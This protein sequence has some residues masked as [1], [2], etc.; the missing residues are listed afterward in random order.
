MSNASLNFDLCI[1]WVEI[2][3][4]WALNSR[5]ILGN[6]YRTAVRRQIARHYGNENKTTRQLKFDVWWGT[7]SCF[8]GLTRVKP[9]EKIVARQCISQEIRISSFEA[10][11]FACQ[12]VSNL[13][14]GLAGGELILNS[15]TNAYGRRPVTTWRAAWL[16][17]FCLA[18][19]ENRHKVPDSASSLGGKESEKWWR[20]VKIH[21]YCVQSAFT[22]LPMTHHAFCHCCHSLNI[23]FDHGILPAKS[24]IRQAEHNITCWQAAA[25]DC[26]LA[27]QAAPA[28]YGLLGYQSSDTAI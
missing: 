24:V 8:P 28:T 4:N 14:L 27:P 15:G 11:S 2:A 23:R 13:C 22:W 19:Y 5:I 6:D 21:H 7:K 16:E 9:C 20:L 3:V 26:F 12:W 18:S 25:Q 1:Y 10:A 17:I